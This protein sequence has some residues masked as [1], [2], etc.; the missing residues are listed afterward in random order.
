MRLI[1]CILTANDCYKA[2]RTITPKGVMV[3]STGANNPAV[4]RYVQPVDTQA[5]AAG[6]Y[7]VLGTNRNKN[8]WNNP[9]LDVCVHAFV[10]KLADGGVG[11]VQ[12]LPWNHR[13]WHAGTGTSGGSANNTHIA[14]EICE[15]GLADA[16]YFGK[17]YQEAVELTAMLCKQYNLNP[18]AD[19]VVICHSEGYQRGVA[20]NHADVMHWFPKHGKNMDTFRQDVSKAM[21]GAPQVKPQAPATPTGKTYTVA[22]G[23]T[24]SGIAAQY[25]TTVDT[26]VELNGIQNPNLIVVGQ[27]LKLP[28]AAGFE[29]YTVK[30]SVT[31]LR[32][33]SGPGTDNASKGF[34]APGVY[35][36]VEEADGQGA[37][38]WGKLKSGAG[39]IS[40]DYTE[41]V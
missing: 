30:V 11:S 39:W 19:G 9:G 34:I 32:I 33:R 8:D 25:G 4:A 23:D 17:V 31:E 14:F 5:D 15:D 36:I 26:L 24:L 27:V 3:H 28:G 1:K 38:R 41:K 40:L 2:G 10:G 18:L 6:L 21:G 37:K 12:T 16:A 29:P 7:T 20:S 13:G 22:K 35:T